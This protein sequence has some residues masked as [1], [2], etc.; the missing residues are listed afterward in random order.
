MRL[1]TIAAAVLAL[2]LAAGGVA[3]AAD[4]LRINPR[5]DYNS[6]SNDGELFVFPKGWQ[7]LDDGR[8]AA[9]LPNLVMFYQ[10]T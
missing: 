8:L 2:C 6:D 10:V 1:G 9:G 7:K 3:P 4:R 5:L